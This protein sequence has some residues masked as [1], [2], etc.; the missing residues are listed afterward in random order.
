MAGAL[1][2]ESE[3]EGAKERYEQALPL[4]R[5]IGDRRGEAGNLLSLGQLNSKL[6]KTAEAIDNFTHGAELCEAIGIDHWAEIARSEAA[7]LSK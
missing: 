3:F 1:E 2:I 7:A 5:Q 6:Q 4:H